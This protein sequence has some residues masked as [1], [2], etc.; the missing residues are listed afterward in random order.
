MRDA[1]QHFSTEQGPDLNSAELI[2][3]GGKPL[4][5]P[6]IIQ[7]LRESS[8]IEGVPEAKSMFCFMRLSTNDGREF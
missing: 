6:P 5:F 2:R 7:G 8:A 4:P 3:M 1:K